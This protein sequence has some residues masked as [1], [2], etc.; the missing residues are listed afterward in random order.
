MRRQQ[1]NPAVR[2]RETGRATDSGVAL[3]S[4]LVLIIACVMLGCQTSGGGPDAGDAVVLDAGDAVAPDQIPA[5]CQVQ[6]TGPAPHQV[7]FRVR[8]AGDRALFVSVAYSCRVALA[9]SSCAGAYADQVVQ[10]Y[11][12]CP[13][14]GD[15]PVGGGGCPP[16]GRAIAPGAAEE[17]D[18]T[19]IVPILSN[20]KGRECH[21]GAR[22]LPSGRYRVAVS[23]F[24]T[25][26]DAT[27][28]VRGRRIE[29]DFELV[30]GSGPQLVEVPL[31]L[32]PTADAAA[33]D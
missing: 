14:S 22:N 24:A 25:Q 32:E 31:V 7:R 29:H 18:W 27:S 30:G 28:N 3:S 15:C 1:E 2:F 4:T 17:R 23:A 33:Q 9:V 6:A 5:A 8:N 12:V 16:D 13:C 11:G 20:Q 19:A 21:L 10:E 26:A